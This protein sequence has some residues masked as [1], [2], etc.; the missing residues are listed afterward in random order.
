MDHRNRWLQYALKADTAYHYGIVGYKSVYNIKHKEK[1]ILGRMKCTNCIG[2]WNIRELKS[3]K[4]L[5][6]GEK[7]YCGWCSSEMFVE[8]KMLN[9]GQPI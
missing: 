7:C 8:S 4:Q 3:W 2:Y 9:V 6:N 1:P 5:M